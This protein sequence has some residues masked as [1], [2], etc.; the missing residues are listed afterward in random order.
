MSVSF[1]RQ[2]A[3]IAGKDLRIE[4]RAR[5]I[6]YTATLFSVVVIVVF[7]FSGFGDSGETRRAAPG[8]LWVTIAFVGT[9]VFGR[10]FQREREQNAIA[11]LLLAPSIVGPLFAA[12]LLVNLALLGA[13]ELIVVPVVTVTFGVPLAAV[14]G[15]VALVVALG[16]LGFAALGTVLAAS[17]STLRLREVLLPI[18][19][20]PLCLPLLL[21]CVK[22]TQL[23]VAG[24]G[25]GAARG[26]LSIVVA[27][28]VLYLALS[29]WLFG[30]A[31]EGSA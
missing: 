15:A 25:L 13:I 6:L 19:L 20:Y 23:L 31:L 17:L 14:G 10:T 16:T 7:L 9:L 2:L 30:Q 3:A 27:F 26:W 11:G 28:D 8:V 1:G 29:R 18:V 21:A 5:E 4:L 22:A 12:K 24:D